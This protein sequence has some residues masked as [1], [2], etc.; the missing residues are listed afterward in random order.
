MSRFKYKKSD[1][2]KKDMNFW[3]IECDDGIHTVNVKFH[4][5]MGTTF[6][7][8][9]DEKHILSI[10]EEKREWRKIEIPCGG[11]VLLLVYFCARM[12]IVHRGMLVKKNIPY[13]PDDVLPKSYCIPFVV[14]NYLSVLFNYILS[15]Y[16]LHFDFSMLA[17]LCFASAFISF[18][19]SVGIKQFANS[20]LFLK[21][22]KKLY[23]WFMTLWCWGTSTV[24]PIMFWAIFLLDNMI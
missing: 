15:K 16:V 4:T 17:F 21:A 24:F 12:D 7:V 19:A 8:Y 18:C 2:D 3:E 14:A 20:P 5:K 13:R 11:E 10:T 22:K 1:L 9:V 23:V 6:D